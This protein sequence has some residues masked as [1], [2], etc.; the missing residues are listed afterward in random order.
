MPIHGASLA[1]DRAWTRAV[2]IRIPLNAPGPT[3]E[4]PRLYVFYVHTCRMQCL[5]KHGQ[6]N[7]RLPTPTC[8]GL[9]V[10]DGVVLQNGN[11][12]L[13]K[14]GVKGNKNVRWAGR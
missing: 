9:G 7:L 6:D 13:L 11:R 14:N 10:D 2:L 5:V 1:T 12:A 3:V 8:H 4:R